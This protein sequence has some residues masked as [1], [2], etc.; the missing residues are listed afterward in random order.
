MGIES[1]PPAGCAILISSPS[2][3]GNQ[4]Q[5]LEAEFGPEKSC[6]LIAV[7]LGHFQIQEYQM[8]AHRPSR[9]KRF[10]SLSHK[11]RFVTHG[12]K[13]ARERLR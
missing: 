7:H 1:G 3:H 10:R 12:R 8:R 4:P 6:Q 9:L 2:G 13:Q 11:H 5:R